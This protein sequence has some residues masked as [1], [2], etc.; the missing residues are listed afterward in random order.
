MYFPS[1]EAKY[2]RGIP[3]IDEGSKVSIA[4]HND[5]L[6]INDNVLIPLNSI[7]STENFR[8]QQVNYDREFSNNIIN[9]TYYRFYRYRIFNI[10]FSLLNQI[11]NCLSVKKL[12]FMSI[13]YMDS[14]GSPSKGL[15][16]ADDREIKR[17]TSLINKR[18]ERE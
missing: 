10:F 7:K 11:F 4:F 6:C 3:E 5:M 18:K 13:E 12:N 1:Y 14:T 17:I 16:L 15:F 2:L 8:V 9:K